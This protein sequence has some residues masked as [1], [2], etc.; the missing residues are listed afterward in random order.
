MT[1]VPPPP[2]PPSFGAPPPG[3][4]PDI[5][6]ALSYGWKKFTENVGPLIGIILA[7]IAALIVLEI[8]GLAVVKGFFGFIFIIAIALLISMILYLGIFN[9]GLMASRGERVDIGKA[10]TTDRWGE[11]ALF[12]VVYGL[13][14]AVGYAACFVG[15]LAVIG[16][17]GLAPFYFL[18]GRK[19]IGESL[20][21]S[22]DASTKRGLFVPLLLL[23]L[24]AAAGGLV[25][26]GGLVTYPV[27]IIGAAFL[28][29]Q[30]TGQPI[31]P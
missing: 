4:G 19:S 20:S 21:A 1:D 31:A 14:L 10:F 27:A 13:M 29:R 25:C 22:F 6:A 7:P 30:V 9:A 2:P 24:V 11:W 8:I 12:A 17:W 5:G 15:V 28:Y 3:S 18:D 26:I 16:V 23:A